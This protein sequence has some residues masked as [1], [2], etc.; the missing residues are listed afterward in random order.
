MI[1]RTMNSDDAKHGREGGADGELPESLVAL[2]VAEED[3]VEDRGRERHGY[4]AELG[5]RAQVEEVGEGHHQD[6]ED[7]EQNRRGDRSRADHGTADPRRAL[8]LA[9]RDVGGDVPREGHLDGAERQRDERDD[10]YQR[11]ELAVVAGAEQAAGQQVE[12]VGRRRRDR[13][14]REQERTRADR[15][16]LRG[17]LA[18]LWRSL[19]LWGGDGGH[20]G[21]GEPERQPS[22][23]LD[24]SSRPGLSERA[25]GREPA[26][27]LPSD[28]LDQLELLGARSAIREG[29]RDLP[30]RVRGPS[31]QAKRDDDA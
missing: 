13:Q 4:E 28:R 12:E 21:T 30:G 1:A 26:H 9:L 11:G 24:A 19:E 31:G 25:S 20:A 29:H 5:D 18:R 15:A 6:E 17:G 27:R 14:R 23:G 7:G 2:H 3:R 16:R 10:R 8:V 22:K